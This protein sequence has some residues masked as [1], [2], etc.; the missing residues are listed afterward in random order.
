MSDTSRRGFIPVIWCG[1]ANLSV[2]IHTPERVVG[3]IQG[4]VNALMPYNGGHF[5][6]M[7][8]HNVATPRGRRGGADYQPVLD[9]N[10]QLQALYP[11]NFLD[12]RHTFI[13]AYNPNDPQDVL[14]HNDDTIPWTYRSD[15]I[16]LRQAGSSWAAAMIRDFIASKGW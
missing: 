4:L 10:A 16:H 8:M 15:E 1:H 6:V 9:I 5:I 12:T 7:S 13:N 14:D 11:S 3:D 2:S